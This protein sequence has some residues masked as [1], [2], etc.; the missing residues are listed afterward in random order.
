[1]RTAAAA[2]IVILLGTTV[3]VPRLFPGHGS[4]TIASGAAP[5]F[6][7]GTRDGAELEVNNAAT[8]QI[9]TQVP[10]PRKGAVLWIATATG[11]L[12]FLVAFVNRQEQQKC[13]G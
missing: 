7:L 12:T 8:G 3:A 2:V 13:T 10:Q 5:P 1:M 6:Y 4:P 11:R 9:V